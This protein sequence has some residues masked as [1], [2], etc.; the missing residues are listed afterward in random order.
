MIKRSS[1]SPHGLSQRGI[2]LIELLV[3]IVIGLLTVIV[4]MGALLVSRNVSGTVSDASQ[5]Q[6]QAANAFRI[7]GQQMRQAGSLRLNLAAQKPEGS[8][9]D[10]A[11]K[12]A[13][14]TKVGDF[15]PV[16]TIRGK[17]SPASSE[18]SVT[19]AFRNYAEPVYTS[20]SDASL[21]RNCL[22]RTTSSSLMQSAFVLYVNPDDPTQRELRCDGSA[23]SGT[24]DPQA[25][26]QNVANFQVRYLVQADVAPFGNPQ[27]RYFDAD[28]VGANW[29]KVT[30]VEVCL[31]LYGTE[32]VEMPSGTAYVDCDS[33]TS[34]DMT[35]LAAPRKNRTHLVFK[36]VYQI[37][38]QGLVKT[39]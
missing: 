15:D 19:V 18:Y 14:E 21:F 31:V 6:Q 35:T 8:A 5:M 24:A 10:M 32:L 22:G 20:A 1:S 9:I 23:P 37:R 12:V 26:A 13:F 27:I 34:V 29:S 16:N 28:G 30:A 36:N 33:S 11:D 38:S 25:I 17:S 7:I 2:S 4:A 39:S 3:G